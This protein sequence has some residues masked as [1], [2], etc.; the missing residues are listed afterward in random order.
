MDGHMKR[1]L[2]A[3]FAIAVSLPWLDG[4]AAAPVSE[5][6][7][8]VSGLTINIGVVPVAQAA[9]FEEK[10]ATSTPKYPS[11]AQHLVVSLSDAKTGG[12]V[13]DAQVVVEI[14]NPQ[15]KTEKK[16]LVPN[17]TSGVPDYSEVFRFVWSGKYVIRVS[18]TPK[19]SH[20][21]LAAA[22][23]WIHEI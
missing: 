6:Q 3:W 17:L 22:F 7:K 19:G 23:T 15:G 12:R 14:K 8:T 11:G 9:G 1:I 4:I 2:C 16:N 18:V 21:S 20:K 5:H 13:G 10:G